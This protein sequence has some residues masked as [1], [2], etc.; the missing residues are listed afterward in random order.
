MEGQLK[1]TE[2]FGSSKN[3]IRQII[4]VE[5]VRGLYRAYWLH[6]MT[7]MPYN[8]IYFSCYDGMRSRLHDMQLDM[9][10]KGTYLPTFLPTYT[11]DVY[12][13]M[14]FPYMYIT[15]LMILVW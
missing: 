9:I 6:Q 7:W 11:Y 1:T 14:L 4:K 12:V 3:A 15:L 10:P 5:G 13:Y 8:G 2:T